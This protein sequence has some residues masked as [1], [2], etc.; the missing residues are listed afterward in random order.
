MYEF[1]VDRARESEFMELMRHLRL[2][3]Q[4]SHRLCGESRKKVVGMAL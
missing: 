3:P 1:E 4:P 2:I